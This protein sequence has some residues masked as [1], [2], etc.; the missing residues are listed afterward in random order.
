MGLDMYL[1]AR[2]YVSGWRSRQDDEWVSLVDHYGMRDFVTDESPHGYVE[3]C[4]A[5]WRKANHIHSWFVREVQD[6]QDECLPHY[7][8]REQL[9]EL[10]S[11]CQD[12]LA[13]RA[14]Y[15]EAEAKKKALEI[16]E[17][18]GG[19]FFGTTEIDAW[20]WDDLEQTVDQLDRVLK[21]N[22]EWSIQYRSSW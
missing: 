9:K 2:Q 1:S 13:Y 20:Y 5:Y 4:V 12:L 19:F 22:D 7:V 15:G 18:Q 11:I 14:R 16:L 17:P 8:S 6:G 3:F 10:R 21:L